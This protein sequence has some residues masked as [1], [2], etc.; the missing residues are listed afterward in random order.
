M[1]NKI[2]KNFP[3]CADEQLERNCRL[4]DFFKLQSLFRSSKPFKWLFAGDSITHG[5]LH[6]KDY[7]RF[8]EIFEFYLGAS[9]LRRKDLVF[10]TGVSGATTAECR[11]Y[12]N[13]WLYSLKADVA[14]I[15]FGMND[16]N[17][18]EITLEM[19]ENNLRRFIKILREQGTLPVLQTPQLSA[20]RKLTDEYNDVIRQIAEK[21]EVLLVDLDEYWKSH[22]KDVRGMMNDPIHP[23]R[24]G[25][26]QWIRLLIKALGLPEVS[27]VLT[28]S[29]KR[30]KGKADAF[31]ETGKKIFA[32]PKVME[33]LAE[34]RVT[35]WLIIG[36]FDS[37]CSFPKRTVP[38][39]FEEILRFKMAKAEER[40]S[41][42]RFCFHLDI[43]R[44]SCSEILDKF[45]FYVG[46]EDWDIIIFYPFEDVRKNELIDRIVKEFPFTERVELN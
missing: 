45:E 2:P 19:Y 16:A 8:S 40:T 46:A 41:L 32:E 25:H 30:L 7:P 9:P 1:Y 14:F 23:N 38:E 33:L 15:C 36:D 37:D 10:N 31:S 12:E 27:E 24:Y 13:E 29:Y 17:N 6:T 43:S 4:S 28:V 35:N 44:I 26:L 42:M 5:C 34:K 11:C 18:D 21:E 3:V 39:H 20:R 22:R